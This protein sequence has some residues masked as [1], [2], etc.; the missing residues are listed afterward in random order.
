[1]FGWTEDDSS[2]LVS[3]ALSTI[4]RV[5]AEDGDNYGVVSDTYGGNEAGAYDAYHGGHADEYNVSSEGADG[6]GAVSDTYGGDKAGYVKDAV[7]GAVKEV[8]KYATKDAK[9]SKKGITAWTPEYP[10]RVL[11]YGVITLYL[12]LVV[13]LVRHAID[14][15]A[16]GRPFFNAVLM[17]VYSELATLGIVEFA[18][19]CWK[20]YGY[21][22]KTMKARF[23]D[24]HFSLFLTAIANGLQYSLTAAIATWFS[25]WM[26]VKT[27]QLDLG[28]YIEIREEYGRID[29]LIESQ[30]MGFPHSFRNCIL[31]FTKPGLRQRYQSLRAQVRFHELRL[32]LLELNNL[33]VTLKIS[34]YLKR[35]EL[36]ILIGLLHVSASSWIVLILGLNVLYFVVGLVNYKTDPTSYLSFH[37]LE[38]VFF[39]INALFILVCWALR[40]KM[41]RIFQTIMKL[42]IVKGNSERGIQRQRQLFWFGSPEAVISLIQLMNFGY[43]VL[44]SIVVIYYKDLNTGHVNTGWYLATVL[45]CYLA[46]L[47]NLSYLLPEYTLCTSLGYL[48][49][50]KALQETV[51]MHRLDEAE[52]QQRLRVV[53]N[54]FVDDSSLIH[55]KSTDDNESDAATVSTKGTSIGSSRRPSLSKALSV[56]DLVKMDTKSLRGQLTEEAAESLNHKPNRRGSLTRKKS[57]SDGVSLMR[58]AE[59]GNDATNTN[60]NENTKSNRRSFLKK[61]LSQPGLIMAKAT[62]AMDKPRSSRNLCVDDMAT[63]DAATRR[64]RKAQTTASVMDSWQAHSAR[65]STGDNT[66][67]VA[68]NV[69]DNAATIDTTKDDDDTISVQSIGNLSDIDNVVQAD[70]VGMV[71]IKPKTIV[72]KNEVPIGQKIVSQMREYFIGSSYPYISIVLGTSVIFLLIGHRLEVM[73][74]LAKFHKSSTLVFFWL[75]FS[76]LLC[77]LVADFMILFIFPLTKYKSNEERRLVVAAIF[78]IIITAVVLALFIYAEVQR[79]CRETDEYAYPSGERELA[80]AKGYAL[81]EDH[82]ES[83][84]ALKSVC[85]CEP[86]GFRVYG[87]FGMVEPFT[88]LIF[89]RL[90]RFVFARLLVPFMF[91]KEPNDTSSKEKKEADEDHGGGHDDHGDSH[92]S[93]TALELWERA[94]SGNPEIVEKHGQFSSELLQAMLGLQVALL[95]PTPL[96][97]TKEKMANEGEKASEWQ[98]HIKLSGSRFAKISPKAQGIVIAGKVGHPVKPMQIHGNDGKGSSGLVE[99]EVDEERIKQENSI[100]YSFVAPFARL[101]R[102][103]RRCD[104]KQLPLFQDWTTVDI[105]MTQ[106]EIVYFEAIDNDYHNADNE[107]ID[108]IAACKLALQA[109][110]GGKNLRLCDVAKGRKVV[111]HLDLQDIT[112]LHV[113]K[114]KAP[115]LDKIYLSKAAGLFDKKSDWNVEHWSDMGKDTEVK[116]KYA[117]MVRWSLIEEDRLKI[118]TDVGLIVLRFYSDLEHFETQKPGFDPQTITKDVAFQWAETFTRICGRDQLEQLLPHFGEG[119]EDELKDYLET[120]NFHEREAEE[121]KKLILRGLKGLG[122]YSFLMAQRKSKYVGKGL[123]QSAAVEYGNSE[124]PA[125][126]ETNKHSSKDDDGNNSI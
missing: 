108:H 37:I 62:A 59:E 5:L 26:W 20:K 27:E 10:Q 35:A 12:I 71:R 22:D 122:K 123:N 33:P 91:S 113:T 1:M 115:V 89:V 23:A 81:D 67:S 63:E 69:G 32:H 25:T 64:I 51:A 15:A 43:A 21:L 41:D 84:L 36:G 3:F 97:E 72:V 47:Y 28:N 55:V 9:S 88:A 114:D 39:V 66:E 87:G 117:R 48:T 24:V 107:T 99:F 13:E 52:R 18:L 120:D 104:R 95:H 93:G 90:L 56:A 38:S 82:Y 116:R 76:I 6:Y 31:F 29:R 102:R 65:V 54:A 2:S 77:F 98:S 109:T 78:D 46:F 111:G 14:H 17:M 4:G 44:F 50:P 30:Y 121:E 49:C 92:D 100:D 19:F 58:A 68:P 85:T 80:E 42:K 8:T 53:E 119:S 112:A 126:K 75:E 40:W 7:K 57:A 94:I 34:D 74:Q 16:K 45:G 101:V 70:E 105:V 11:F 110:G 60:E 61:T 96:Q 79:C 125:S 103:M 86:F 73:S 118:T 83:N 124:L 106:F